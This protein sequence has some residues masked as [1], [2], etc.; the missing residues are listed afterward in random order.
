MFVAIKTHQMQRM[1]FALQ[2]AHELSQQKLSCGKRSFSVA[3]GMPNRNQ[4]K[5][6]GNKHTFISTLNLTIAMHNKL[7]Q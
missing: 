7:W 5:F 1:N 6:H 4:K 3:T 2:Q